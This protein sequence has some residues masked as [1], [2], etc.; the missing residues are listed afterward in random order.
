[1]SKHSPKESDQSLQLSNYLTLEHPYHRLPVTGLDRLIESLPPGFRNLALNY[2]LSVPVITL[3]SRV[4]ATAH[5]I[6]HYLDPLP[7]KAPNAANMQETEY[8]VR[9]LA[10]TKLT[11]IERSICMSIL[12]SVLDRTRTERFSGLYLQHLQRH[13][14]ELSELQE[15]FE[16]PDLSD[17]YLWAALHIAGTMIPPKVPALSS[18]YER[19]KRFQLLMAVMQKY[20]HLSWADCLTILQSFIPE[21]RC[22]ESWHNSWKLGL[23]HIAKPR[24]CEVRV[25]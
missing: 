24:H 18:D 22:V 11:I 25:R 23:M 10:C 8:A 17:F 20:S 3:I 6:D 12:V 7:S 2:R 9:L 4:T 13:A 5:D 14:G 19:D 21:G 15:L 16:E 1:M